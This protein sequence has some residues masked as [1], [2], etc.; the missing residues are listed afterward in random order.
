MWSKNSFLV[1]SSVTIILFQSV[2]AWATQVPRSNLDSLNLE[3]YGGGGKL[4]CMRK[5]ERNHCVNSEK[6]P[7]SKSSNNNNNK[8]TEVKVQDHFQNS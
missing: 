5:A 4:V 8:A 7:N 1:A 2:P 3:I 6:V